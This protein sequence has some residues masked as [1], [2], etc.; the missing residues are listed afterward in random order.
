M[1]L[2]FGHLDFIDPCAMLFVCTACYA[3]NKALRDMSG[4]VIL[5]RGTVAVSDRVSQPIL[6]FGKMLENGWGIDG[7]Q[8]MLVHTSAGAAIPLELQNKSM[9]VHGSIRVLTEHC[10]SPGSFHVRAI[11]AEVDE[12]IVNGSVGWQL[13]SNGCG[14]G[15][16]DSDHHQDPLLV[17]PD[18]DGKFY[19]T[20]FVE[21]NNKKW[22]VMELC[23]Q[24]E[25]LVQLDSQFHELHGRRN[26]ITFITESEKDPRVMGFS[27]VDEPD[28]VFPVEADA[29]QD[30]EVMDVEPPIEGRD[31][32]EGQIVV[33]PIPEDE[34]NVNGTALRETSSLA[35]LRAGCS[36]YGVSSSGSIQKC[37]KRLIEH[38]KKLELELVMA[39]AKEA[40]EQQE[41]HPLAPVSAEVP[42]EYEQSQHR[43]MCHTS[44]GALHVLLTGHALTVMNA[45]V[46][47][48]QEQ[49]PPYPLTIASQNLMVRPV[50]LAALTQ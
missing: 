4:R 46:N 35:G 22:Y 34:V 5:L 45:Q 10:I 18:M 24:L 27:L 44:S 29:D 30:I 50:I 6:S 49:C 41:R 12:G 28:E 19:R 16:Q 47:R 31:V 17:R 13:D 32:P 42:T 3:L 26:V 8:Q 20:T 39:A 48:M 36:F 43:H 11:Q 25:G 1:I 33:Q 15:R 38:S 7:S 14:I 40:F 9:I 23:E 2:L 21:G 37:F